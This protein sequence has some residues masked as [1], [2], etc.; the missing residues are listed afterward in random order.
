M[1]L[2][3]DAFVRKFINNQTPFQYLPSSAYL[4]AEEPAKAA[5]KAA[6]GLD[7]LIDVILVGETGELDKLTQ[8]R[9]SISGQIIRA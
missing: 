5:N 2:T 9:D 1:R 6:I 4:T 3:K 7:D 8:I